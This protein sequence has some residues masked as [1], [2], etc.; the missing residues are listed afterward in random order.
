[1]KARK[2]VLLCEASEGDHPI[3]Q[4]LG[5]SEATSGMHTGC[6]AGR[7][8]AAALQGQPT[9]DDGV[10]RVLYAIFLSSFFSFSMMRFSS[11]DM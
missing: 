2:S 3:W 4:G 6:T 9:F 1:M 8:A 10:P 11:L 7:V 5:G